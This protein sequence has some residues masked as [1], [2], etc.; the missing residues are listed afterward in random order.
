MYV[1]D[2]TRWKFNVWIGVAFLSNNAAEMRQPI[3]TSN[4]RRIEFDTAEM[5]R[6]NRAFG[7]IGW[8][9]NQ[10]FLRAARSLQ[11]QRQQQQTSRVNTPS[12]RR[13]LLGDDDYDNDDDNK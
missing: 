6:M 4:F 8:A 11:K 10:S 5:G 13:P 2:P 3:E 9:I 1:L 7:A 12:A